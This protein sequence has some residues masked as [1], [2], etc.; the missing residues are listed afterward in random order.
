MPIVTKFC[1]AIKTTDYALWKQIQDGGRP[2]SWKNRKSA[3]SPERFEWS[4]RNLAW[5]R[6]S[7]LRTGPEVKIS[8]FKKFKMAD[9][10][11]LQKIEKCIHLFDRSTAWHWAWWRIFAL[12]AVLAGKISNF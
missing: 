6:K 11:H 7:A 3:I 10:R 12:R 9:C 2:L 5:W 8:N 4:V 1:T